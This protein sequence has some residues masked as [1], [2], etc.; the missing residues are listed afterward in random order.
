MNISGEVTLQR[1]M[2]PNTAFSS[3]NGEQKKNVHEAS[4][5]III[6]SL[7]A[8]KKQAQK[9]G[10]PCFFHRGAPEGGGWDTKNA[11][12]HHILHIRSPRVAWV[13]V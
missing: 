10:G 12:I 3:H 4:R 9:K 13:F 11:G 5:R 2:W 1:D 6:L 7:W 8:K